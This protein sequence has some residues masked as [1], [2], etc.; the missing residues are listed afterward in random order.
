MGILSAR[1]GRIHAGIAAKKAYVE[2]KATNHIQKICANLLYD[3]AM[4]S[5]QWSGDYASNWNIYVDTFPAYSGGF[6]VHPWQALRGEE[7]QRGDPEAVDATV[8]R[9]MQSID[10]IRWNMQIR[11]ANFA[12]VS[13]SLEAGQINLRPVNKLSPEMSVVSYLKMNYRCMS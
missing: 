11:L 12:L 1:I 6:K 5:P 4:A 7:K 13:D 8:L 10:K 3:A 9:G 2:E